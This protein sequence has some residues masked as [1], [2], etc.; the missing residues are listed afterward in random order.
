M[1]VY[2]F[3]FFIIAQR[4]IEVIIAKNNERWMKGQG[5]Y[6]VG[7]EHYVYIVIV[8]VMFF[9]SLLLEVTVRSPQFFVW[10][11]IPFSFFMIAQVCRG[12][13]LSSLG[14]FWNTRII[15]LPGAKVKVKGPYQFIRHPNYVIV[16]TELLMLPLMFQAYVTAVVFTILNGWVLSIRIKEEE[17]A[18]REATDY[19]V[20]FTHKKR[21]VPKADK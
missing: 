15:V 3:I 11:I 2:L 21:F 14:R 6:E 13:A 16:I 20:Q 12:W 10:S 4:V 7:G 19:D 9:V 18:L 5:G 17:K 8:H 1:I